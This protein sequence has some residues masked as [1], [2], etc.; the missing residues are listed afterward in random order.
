MQRFSNSREL[1]PR[2]VKDLWFAFVHHVAVIEEKLAKQFQAINCAVDGCRDDRG[3]DAALHAD[4]VRREP[5]A[6]SLCG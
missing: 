2:M 4:N 3:S 5:I 1:L 6:E